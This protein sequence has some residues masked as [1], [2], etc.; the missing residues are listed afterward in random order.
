M[1]GNNLL[2]TWAEFLANLKQRSGTSQY[3]DHQG[4]LSKL[5]QTT[6]VSEFQTAFEDLMNKVTGISEQLLISFFITGLQPNIRREMML[7]RPAT[8]ME[9]FALARAYEARSEDASQDQHS[10]VKGGL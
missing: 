5:T 10:W 8:L 7:T 6:T 3:E 9:A 4:S 1:K 2:T